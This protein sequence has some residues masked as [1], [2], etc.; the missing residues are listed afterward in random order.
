M[1]TYLFVNATINDPVKFKEYAEQAGPT[2]AAFNAKPLVRG[3]VIESICGGNSADIVAIVE[4]ESTAQLKAW[5]QSDDYQALI[6]LRDEAATVN[7]SI[8]EN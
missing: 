5:Y 6:P 3:K 4:F 8:I 2:M 7:L 1:S